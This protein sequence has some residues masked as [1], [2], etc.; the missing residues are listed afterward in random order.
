MTL[1]S[2]IRTDVKFMV[3]N[4]NG[5][6]DQIDDNINLAIREIA[7]GT[8]PQELWVSTTFTTSSG[9][10]EY[11]FATMSTPVT[12]LMAVMFIRNSTADV[13][14]K[15]GGLSD[16]F[17]NKIVATGFPT[18][19]PNRW[20]RFGNTLVL[21][22][23][24][25]DGASRTMRMLYLQRPAALSADSDTF[26]LNAEWEQPVKLLASSYTWTD[27][28]NTE[29]AVLKMQAYDRYMQT[30]DTPVDIEDMAPEASL[31]FVSNLNR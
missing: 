14:V 5:I 31:Q 29:K 28:N 18:G 7:L 21:Y 15:R 22:S 13:T 30:V 26:P 23:Q 3:G 17:N 24:I 8:R 25:P 10:A 12:D 1:L 16:Y 4:R 19:D 2:T 27:L 20:T 11:P 9:V 6:D